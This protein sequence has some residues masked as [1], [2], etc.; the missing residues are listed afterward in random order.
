MRKEELRS[1]R[2]SWLCCQ[3]MKS[4]K[5]TCDDGHWHVAAQEDVREH[6]KV[7]VAA[8]CG[9]ENHRLVLGQEC[10]LQRLGIERWKEQREESL[11]DDSFPV[12]DHK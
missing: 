5:Q 2:G 8:V 4:E 10:N 3:E 9:Q 7:H 12:Q 11:C 6:D 1:G